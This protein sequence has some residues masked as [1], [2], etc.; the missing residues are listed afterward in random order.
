MPIYTV[1]QYIH[2]TD[3]KCLRPCCEQH[4]DNQETHAYVLLILVVCCIVVRMYVP[5]TEPG[6][7]TYHPSKKIQPLHRFAQATH[8][9][10]QNYIQDLTSQQKGTATAVHHSKDARHQHCT[11]DVSSHQKGTAAPP[12]HTRT[13]P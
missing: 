11:Q 5:R 12:A 13:S 10:H 6:S 7:K 2:C 8:A 3:S 9:R 4:Y 1:L